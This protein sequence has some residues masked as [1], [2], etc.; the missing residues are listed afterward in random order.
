MSV[1]Q[2]KTIM[3]GPE[4]VSS[5]KSLPRLK[6]GVGTATPSSKTVSRT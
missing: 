3:A 2:E 6:R 5:A 1:T 4:M